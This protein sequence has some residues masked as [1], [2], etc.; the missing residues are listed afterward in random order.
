MR[1]F[2]PVAALLIAFALSAAYPETGG[3]TAPPDPPEVDAT[4]EQDAEVYLARLQPVNAEMSDQA[5]SGVA[6]FVVSGDSLTILVEAAGLNPG[7]MHL[8]HYHGFTDGRDAA[9]APAAADDNADAVVDLIETRDYSGITLVPF[10]EQPASLE[11]QATTYPT[12]SQPDGEISYVQTV[13]IPELERALQREH[14][15]GALDLERRVVYLHGVAPATVLP[16]TVQSLGEVPAHVTL[17]VACGELR[18]IL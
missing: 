6:L 2:I 8:Q 11:I 7:Q 1:L 18:Q 3:V 4:A 10:H 5:V 17:P 13:P 12:A 16:E 14:G 15:I 9:C